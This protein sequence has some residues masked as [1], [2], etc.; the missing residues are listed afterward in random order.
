MS[1]AK[2]KGTAAETA[3]VKYLREK[4][5]KARRNALT[6]SS[7]GGDIHIE[8]MDN[9]V[10]EVKNQARLSIPEWLR[11]VDEEKIN[12]GARNGILIVKPRGVGLD[13]AGKFWVI[14]RLE[15]FDL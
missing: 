8:G 15:D 7:D 3:V 11:Q 9:L 5:F 13:K 14:Q 6:G 10:I 2:A 4:G 12:T 1:K